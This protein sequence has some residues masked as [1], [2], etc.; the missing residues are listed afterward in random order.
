MTTLHKLTAT[1]TDS[2]ERWIDYLEDFSTPPTQ[3][4]IDSTRSLIRTARAILTLLDPD[5]TPF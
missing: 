5:A 2:L 4:D 1:L 3:E